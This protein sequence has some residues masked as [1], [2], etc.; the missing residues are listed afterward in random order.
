[1]MS[2]QRIA[3]RILLPIAAVT[4]VFTVAMY[5]VADYTIGQLMERNLYRL[6]R[7]KVADIAASEKRVAND[8]LSQA[9][10]FSQAKP[11]LEAYQTAHQGNLNDEADQHMEMARG[12]LRSYFSSIEKGFKENSENKAL[13]LHF[14][15][16][17]AR[18]LLR[19]WKKDQKKSDDLS[20][21]RETVTTIS[22]GGHQR[23]VGVEVGVGGFE[24]RGIVPVIS[25]SGKYMGSVESLSSYGPL[26]QYGVSNDKEHIAVYMN[27][28]LLPI[29]TELQDAAKH[30]VVGDA[31][32]FVSSS[33]QLVTDAVV[34]A[35]M[36]A[37]GQAGIKMAGTGDYFTTVFPIN[38]FSG[39]QV[40]VMAY[41]YNASELYQQMRRMKQGI[42][43][44][45]LVLLVAVIVPLYF[46]VRSVTTPIRRTAAMLKD[47]AEGEGDLTKRLQI[48]K[49]DELGE[50]AHWF[51]VFLDRL[52]RLV[53]DFGS[54]AHSLRLSSDDLSNIAQELAKSAEHSSAKS[55]RMAGGAESMSASMTSV[56]AASEQAATN[57][58]AVASAVHEMAATVR[59]IAANSER[60][61]VTAQK[62]ATGATSTSDKVN[63]LGMDVNDIGK[64]T[65]VI[66]EISEQTNL[67]ALN[68]TIEAARA[69]E[70]GKGFAVVANE[71]KELAKQTAEATGEI[72]GKIA[73][74]QASTGE[75]VNEI[76]R[77][78]AVINEV[79]E[80]V[81]AIAAAVEEQSASTAEIAENLSQASQ[82]IQD[83]N[84]NIAVVST[85]TGEIS[86]DIADVSR[87]SK[88]VNIV[89][90]QLTS[91]ARDLLN[92]S[93][94]L[95]EV[96]DR[97]K[98]E[99]ARFDLG[100]VKAAHM[101]W[102]SRLEMVLNGKQALRPE[103]VTSDRDCEFGKWYHGVGSQALSGRP[104]F[105]AVGEQHA[106]V[107]QY[108]RQVV[109]LVKQGR[110]E[111]AAAL[112]REFELTREAFFKALDELYL[113]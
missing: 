31:F 30:P 15:V 33:D 24:I 42:I 8:M 28:A 37:G 11:V 61:R 62:A 95:A 106:R 6:G 86:S 103:E 75:T 99:K 50:L 48:L 96:I 18:S 46:S 88:D 111:D 67:L 26:V 93:E 2:L 59:E 20:S 9:A 55:E 68:A 110:K 19:V 58:D 73:N 70:Y 72:K 13:R 34:T 101:Q 92:L 16:P 51:N 29:A 39:K 104:H 44:L 3:P 74:I 112:M 53:K 54:K 82:G 97:F 89:S 36:L 35:E 87:G 76:E 100:K 10:L 23:I 25:E 43:V 60:T 1:M 49:K 21:F 69:G 108:A 40:G 56:A 32:V 109:E 113:S 80:M 85:L 90:C 94:R 78:S 107:H 14:H 27:K 91:S 38:D 63:R 45:C 83:V 41:V 4:V 7:S 84:Q 12:Q 5:L 22:T 71:I 105:A 79:N 17:P 81:G 65:E 57:V 64:V 77:I 52:E 98:T 47:I 102:R 66:T